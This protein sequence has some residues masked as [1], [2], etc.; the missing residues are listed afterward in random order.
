[1]TD[2]I[3]MEFD[4]GDL[5]AEKVLECET[6]F[7]A[8]CAIENQATRMIGEQFAKA[9]ENLKHLRNG[10]GWREWCDKKLNISHQS[11]ENYINEY[12]NGEFVKNFD[13]FGKSARWLLVAP[14]T[15][16]EVRDRADALA[17]A[18]EDVSVKTI[19]KIKADYEAERQASELFERRAQESQAESNERRK[20]VRELEEQIDLLTIRDRMMQ[21][22]LEQ[23]GQEIDRL[24]TVVPEP[25]KIVVPPDDYETAKVKA[26]QLESALEALK[27]EQVKLINSQVKAKLHEYQSEV[28]EMERRK[29]VLQEQVDRMKA[30]MASKDREDRR[31]A[32]HQQVIEE[33]R[34]KL[35]S[36]AVFL[37][38]EDP[39]QDADTLKL[40]RALAD[41][42]AEAMTAVRQYS[43]ESRPALSVVRGE[44]A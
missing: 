8:A 41:M 32:V 21:G 43:G 35:L 34:L 5:P 30:Y 11:A 3:S 36:L 23:A 19:K 29:T 9:K 17:E 10:N 18:G 33:L 31:L 37:S 16:Q 22:R 4:Y 6:A 38:D 26:A 13:K 25:E 20:K 28:D 27:K 7:Q 39:V 1:M 2:M 12:K 15:P 24:A 40:W 42:L 14:N 44:V